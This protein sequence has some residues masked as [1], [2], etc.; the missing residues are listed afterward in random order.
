LGEDEVCPG[1][2]AC[3]DSE[4]G[5]IGL[6]E[7]EVECNLPLMSVLGFFVGLQTRQGCI[8]MQQATNLLSKTIT[9]VSEIVE[10]ERPFGRPG[11]HPFFVEFMVV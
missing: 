9:D 4:E 5:E 1:T 11:L 10:S 8:C 7:G 2:D 6:E 3:G